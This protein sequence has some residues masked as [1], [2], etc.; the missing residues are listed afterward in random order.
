MK[1]GFTTYISNPVN[2]ITFTTNSAVNF[3]AAALTGSPLLGAPIQPW[4]YFSAGDNM[5]LEALSVRLP[6]CFGQA[7]D[8][9]LLQLEYISKDS[10]FSG[11]LLE[12]GALG[13]INIPYANSEVDL[14][15]FIP[16]PQAID[17]QPWGIRL[18]AIDIDVSMVN[19]P[20]VLDA[21]ELDIY[22]SARVHTTRPMVD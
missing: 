5:I 14:N 18:V 3:V 12:I 8:L 9:I 20:A 11:S 17:D 2:T 16:K 6:Y 19:M 22:V 15:I 7:E 13:M 21:T 1:E 4:P 10:V